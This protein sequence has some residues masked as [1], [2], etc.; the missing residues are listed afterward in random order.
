MAGRLVLSL[1][2]PDCEIDGVWERES[3]ARVGTHDRGE[4]ESI[5]ALDV[6]AKCKVE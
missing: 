1:V 6:F 2:V 5:A 3:N 4:I